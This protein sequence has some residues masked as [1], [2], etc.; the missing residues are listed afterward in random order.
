MRQRSREAWWKAHLG[1]HRSFVYRLQPGVK[2]RLHCDSELCR[3][4]HCIDF[5]STERQFVNAFLRPGDIFVD[6]GANIGLFTLV[7]AGRVGAEGKV[8]AFEPTK[9][10]F[11]RLEA[12]VKLNGFTNTSLH[13]MALSDKAEE[14]EIHRSMDGFDGWNTFGKLEAGKDVAV[15]KVS[16]VTWDA[17][18]QQHNLSGRVTMMKIDVEGWES[19]VLRGGEAHFSRPDA[20]VLQVEFTEDAAK[21]AGST[22]RALYQQ[23]EALGYRMHAFDPKTQQLTADPLREE[24]PYLNLFAIKNLEFANARLGSLDPSP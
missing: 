6:V 10:T 22:C 8:Y 23:L 14:M 4:I 20:P 1:E 15:E 21:A 7:A 5:E 16:S 13:R 12:N 19:F 18:A 24:Y 17:F 9:Q 3:L 2:I 11:E